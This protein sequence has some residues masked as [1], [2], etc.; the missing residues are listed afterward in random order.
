MA[1]PPGLIGLACGEISRY[2]DFVPSIVAMAAVSPPGT[3]FM[4]ATG[5]GP[6]TPFNCIARAFL[7]NQQ[8]QWLFLTN[9]DNL[10]PPDTIHRLLAHNVDMVSGLYFG[11]I[12][13][14]EPIL[15][16]S[17]EVV[18][19]RKWYRRHLMSDGE[20]GL[21]PAAAVGD[22]CLLIRR[23]VME[24]L[25][26]PWWEYGETLTDACDHDVVFSR[27][28]KEA[29]FGLHCDLDLVVDHVAVFSVRPV[30]QPDGRWEAHL[31]QGDGRSIALPAASGAQMPGRE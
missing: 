29:G 28:V 1:H 21:I 8:Y 4:K 9:D 17:V 19:G 7:D 27:K 3:G 22:G 30:R 13:P 26:D 23:H 14:F 15:F 11:R 16:D 31:V 10:C 2:S 20:G 18:N 12:Q 24:A 25:A 5:L 6:A